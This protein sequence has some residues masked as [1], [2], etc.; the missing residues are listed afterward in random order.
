[1]AGAVLTDANLSAASLQYVQNLTQAQIND[2][3]CNAATILPAHLEHPASRLKIAR[4]NQAEVS[5]VR[6]PPHN[7]SVSK[8]V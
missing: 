4:E 2:S 5:R 3:I 7:G 6:V 1:M 8:L